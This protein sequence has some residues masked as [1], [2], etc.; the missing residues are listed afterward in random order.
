[1]AQTFPFWTKIATFPQAA[2]TDVFF[3]DPFHGLVAL[4]FGYSNVDSVNIFYTRDQITWLKAIAPPI[5]EIHAIREIGGKLYAAVNAPDLLVSSDSGVTW[6][7]SGLEMDSAWD[8]YQD[9]FGNIRVLNGTQFFGATFA[10]VD[11]FHCLASGLMGD[12]LSGDGG[13]TWF[14]KTIGLDPPG[15]SNYGDTCNH[16]LLYHNVDGYVYASSDNGSTWQPRGPSFEPESN[17]WIGY[18]IMEGTNS[19]IYINTIKGFNRTTDYGLT[20][21]PNVFFI[22]LISIHFSV[23]GGLGQ[24][25]VLGT[26]GSSGVQYW[27][28]I[29]ITTTGGD[30]TLSDPINLP[31]S[32]PGSVISNDTIYVTSG[33]GPK[34]LPIPIL[35][36][37]ADSIFIRSSIIRNDSDEFSLSGNDQFFLR[38][39][40]NDTLWVRYMPYSN[41]EVRTATLQ[42]HNSWRCSDWTETRMIIVTTPP[43]A[44]AFAPARMT[45]TC[46]LVVDSALFSIDSCQSLALSSIQ[47]VGTNRISFL[48]TLPDTIRSGYQTSLAF[49]FDPRDTIADDSVHVEIKGRYI[50]TSIPFDTIIT[51]AYQALGAV[52]QLSSD[53]NIDFGASQRCVNS[54]SLDTI[55]TFTNSGCAPDTITAAQ[56]SG[57]GF[58]ISH[59]SLPI[60]VQSGDSA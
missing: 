9:G 60:I 50:G 3:F 51:I 55:L 52:P 1:M 33:C 45:G 36:Q 46:S 53:S 42:F 6:N 16:V 32:L 39:N 24:N 35:E 18:P 59:D 11:K 10:R 29:W 37:A 27:S 21:E 41:P 22:N 47:I 38:S 19:T 48:G 56:L 57:E 31:D 5:G 26:K 30:G 13:I 28:D 15:F 14:P 25:V 34:L 23:F 54:G 2:V 58:L 49:Q 7:F 17:N 4:N 40:S 12:F 43:S 20:W 44:F 8:V